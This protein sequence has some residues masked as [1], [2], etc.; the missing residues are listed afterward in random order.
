MKRVALI[1]DDDPLILSL[2]QGVLSRRGYEVAAFMSAAQCP[3]YRDD[4]C[5][6]SLAGGCPN[7][8][9]TDFDMPGVNGMEFIEKLRRKSCKCLDVVLMSGSYI[10]CPTLRRSTALGVTF[11]A[12][13][14]H[15]SQIQTWLDKIENF[16]RHS[17]LPC[18]TAAG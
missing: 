16:G 4:A 1:L 7:I 9:L 14:F 10:D 15:M 8:I 3:A 17:F 13:P 6:C 5:P 18:S 11:I 2:L 12:K